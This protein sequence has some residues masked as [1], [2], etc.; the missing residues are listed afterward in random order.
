MTLKKKGETDL[1]KHHHSSAGMKPKTVRKEIPM[2]ATETIEILLHFSP[3][4]NNSEH[5]LPQNSLFSF[6]WH[7]IHPPSI[8]SQPFT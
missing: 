2:K 6:L 4:L 5:N 1:D 3:F 7:Q 8:F